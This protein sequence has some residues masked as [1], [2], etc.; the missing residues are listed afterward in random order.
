MKQ[1]LLQYVQ[2]KSRLIAGKEPVKVKALIDSGAEVPVINEELLE[3][4]KVEQI[5][6]V[7]LQCVA[8]DAIPAKLV[9]VDV[10]LC[11]ND[12][13]EEVFP[14]KVSCSLTPYVTLMCASIAKM[15]STERFLLHPDI[16]AELK[17][18]PQV[19]M[20][21]GDVQANVTTRLQSQRK[22][23]VNVEEE[24]ETESSSEEENESDDQQSLMQDGVTAEMNEQE[25]AACKNGNLNETKED[26]ECDVYIG[27][28][29][30]QD[31]KDEEQQMQIADAKKFEEQQRQDESL[32]A[33]WKLA[34][35]KESEFCVVNGLLYKR[36]RI[37]DQTIYQLVLPKE[38]R[39][40]VMELA[41][42]SVFGGH[43][44]EEKTR[45]RIKLSFTWPKMR[46]DIVKFC[47]SCEKCQL[48]ARSLVMDRVP[49]T[50]IAREDVAFRRITMDCVGPIEPASAAGHKYCLCVVDSCTRW[51][52][53]FLLKSLTAKAV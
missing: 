17:A 26:N 12:V 19:R 29:F 33:W 40:K 6:K 22:K 14:H 13:E 31:E 52:T 11:C 43:L 30:E 49:I 50:P 7:N 38:R 15:G 21:Q 41:H 2:V 44:G 9:K 46:R 24:S 16:I 1:V 32:K 4:M 35:D 51:P 8:G 23:V 36:Y 34:P 10:R 53:V 28:L 18:V 5:G 3:V 20:I 47:K 45:E 42:E 48:K 27:D 25:M 39:I 37:L